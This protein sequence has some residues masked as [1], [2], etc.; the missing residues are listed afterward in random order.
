[1]VQLAINFPM[2]LWVGHHNTTLNWLGFGVLWDLSYADQKCWKPSFQNQLSLLILSILLLL[3]GKKHGG[4]LFLSHL[5]NEASLFSPAYHL[6]LS[7]NTFTSHIS[8]ESLLNQFSTAKRW[9]ESPG[10]ESSHL[11]LRRLR[12]INLHLSLLDLM[13]TEHVTVLPGL[14]HCKRKSSSI[15]SMF[16]WRCSSNLLEYWAIK[17]AE[18]INLILFSVLMKQISVW[19]LIFG[20]ECEGELCV[21]CI[22]SSS[23]LS[24]KLSFYHG[25]M[26]RCIHWVLSSY[27]TESFKCF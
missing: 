14:F 15:I 6:N 23:I 21:I 27:K 1:M 11:I 16:P 2:A 10:L 19:G 12:E 25:V 26:Y 17:V 3:V 13:A 5:H 9:R 7:W 18:G 4:N 8:S 24:N 20:K 22:R